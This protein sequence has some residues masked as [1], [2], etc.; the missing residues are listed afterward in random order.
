MLRSDWFRVALGMFLVAFGANFFAPMVVV[1]QLKA[2]LSFSQSSFLFGVYALGLMVA[3]F[4]GGPLSDSLGRKTIMRPAV[5]CTLVGSLVLMLGNSGSFLVLL[6]GRLIIGA[7]VGLAMSSGAA[8]L[9]ELSTSAVTGARRSSISLSLGFSLAPGVCGLLAEFAPAP[10]LLPFLA[11][12]SLAILIIPLVW[13]TPA[14]HCPSAQ[15]AARRAAHRVWVP[16]SIFN[17]RFLPVAVYAPWVFGT[18]TTGLVFM[19]AL[20][21]E[22]SA[23]PVLLTGAIAFLTMGTGV[24]TQ[25]LA[26]RFHFTAAHGMF[27]AA[28]GMALCLLLATQRTESWTLWLLP[29]IA[30]VMGSAYGIT[31]LTGL[32]QTQSLA[33][34]KELGAATG[35]FYSLTYLGFFAPFI[36]SRLGPAVGYSATF[37]CG[38]V[39]ALLTTV[40]LRELGRGKRV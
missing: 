4:L 2:G 22:H 6:V 10:T 37:M 13:T 25:R 30:I 14:D 7:A 36:L 28:I 16:R 35:V 38:V 18:A 31:M 24:A 27:L 1:Y 29:L 20:L 40:W 26:G 39:I 19:P 15:T 21:S 8:W 34:P 5:A 11:P 33:D 17:R 9:K 12:V 3:L 32:A 23:H